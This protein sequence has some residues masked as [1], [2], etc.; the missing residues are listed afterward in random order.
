M[1]RLSRLRRTDV[2]LALYARVIWRFR[3]IVAVGLLLAVVLALFSF[4]KVGFKDGSPTLSYRQAET[5]AS[6]EK[7]LVTQRGFPWGRTVFPGSVTSTQVPG[8][9]APGSGVFANSSRFT[10][11]AIFYAQ[12]AN[13]DAVRAIAASRRLPRG[14]F[15]A[16]PAV[17]PNSLGGGALP[18]IAISGVAATPKAAIK[19]STRGSE[20]FKKYLS[21]RQ[22]AASIPDSQRVEVQTINRAGTVQILS[23][24]SKTPPIVVFIAVMMAA[25]GITFILENVRPRVRLVAAPDEEISQVK[26]RRGA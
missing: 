1:E 2:D 22:R 15:F 23:G 17:N 19:L 9:T 3:L 7:L 24:R 12:L 18:I 25:L 10:E 11:L 14:S 26:A 13:S 8:V 6:E 4:V 20:A 5:W 16:R 21:S